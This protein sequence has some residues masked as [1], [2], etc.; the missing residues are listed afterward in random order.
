MLYRFTSEIDAY[1][2][3]IMDYNTINDIRVT[4][5]SK[6]PYKYTDSN[7][8]N[9]KRWS[10]HRELLLFGTSVILIRNCEDISLVKPIFNDSKCIGFTTYY[11]KINLLTGV[12]VFDFSQIKEVFNKTII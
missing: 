8:D 3:L 10:N 11:N 1:K 9:E 6:S 4:I 12:R 2:E 7:S 5:V